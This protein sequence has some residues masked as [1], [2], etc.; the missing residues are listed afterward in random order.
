M[1]YLQSEI[2]QIVKKVKKLKKAKYPLYVYKR[3]NGQEYRCGVG[4]GI[5]QNL[6][7]EKEKDS[8]ATVEPIKKIS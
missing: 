6:Q 2:D 4:N 8:T 7:Y 1:A 5:I 3:I